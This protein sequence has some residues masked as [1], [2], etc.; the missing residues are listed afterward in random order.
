MPLSSLAA[1][2]KV[3]MATSKTVAITKLGPMVGSAGA[4]Q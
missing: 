4:A 3:R 2:S 1:A